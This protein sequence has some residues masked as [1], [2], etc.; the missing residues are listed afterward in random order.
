[1]RPTK[2]EFLGV[3]PRHSIKVYLWLKC[4][5]RTKNQAV[6]D[7]SPNRQAHVRSGERLS[8]V[9]RCRWAGRTWQR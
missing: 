4:V 6:I 8:V 5:A 9:T 2:S 7:K 1:M 3:G